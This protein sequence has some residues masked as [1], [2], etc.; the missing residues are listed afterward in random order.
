MELAAAL[1]TTELFKDLPEAGVKAIAGIGEPVTVSAGDTLLVEGG[2][3]DALWV[4]LRGACCVYTERGGSTQQVVKLGP[5]DPFGAS[6]VLERTARSATVVATEAAELVAFRA[7]ALLAILDRDVHT[8]AP[9]YKALAAAMFRRM[10]QTT[11]E[12]GFARLDPRRNA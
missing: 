9:F 6:A 12:L 8:A 7:D 1:K 11:N 3:A 5:G 10:R 4:I 2:P